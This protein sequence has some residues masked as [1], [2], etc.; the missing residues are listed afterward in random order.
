MNCQFWQLQVLHWL[1]QNHVAFWSDF[2]SELSIEIEERWD[3]KSIGKVFLQYVSSC[4]FSNPWQNTCHTLHI[5]AFPLWW[6]Y[7][8]SSPL[9]KSLKITQKISNPWKIRISKFFVKLKGQLHYT[10][11][12]EFFSPFLRFCNVW[13]ENSNDFW[14]G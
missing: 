5:Y 9:K 13:R 8:Q 4:A 1:L 2:S 6:V 12:D 3:N 14:F 11:F 10:N 7:F